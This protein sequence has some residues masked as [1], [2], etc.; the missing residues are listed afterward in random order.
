M[1]KPERA[2]EVVKAAV[3]WQR[4]TGE[5]HFCEYDRGMRKH[6]TDCPLVEHDFIDRH[7]EEAET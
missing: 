6:S 1:E 5:C 3:A 4:D 7:G 2:L